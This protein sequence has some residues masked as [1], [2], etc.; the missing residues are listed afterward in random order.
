MPGKALVSVWSA[1]SAL[2][3]SC[4]EKGETGTLTHHPSLC[5]PE[6][7]E[8]S[9]WGREFFSV[10]P[11]PRLASSVASSGSPASRACACTPEG[12]AY[13]YGKAVREGI[14]PSVTPGKG[15][16]VCRLGGGP[17]TLGMAPEEATQVP[18]P[19]GWSLAGGA[20]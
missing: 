15:A 13:G 14:P 16:V 4:K 8:S 20:R 19:L 10:S 6:A 2:T 12:C 7:F 3:H 9:R 11:R 5:F 17:K 18:H 1:A